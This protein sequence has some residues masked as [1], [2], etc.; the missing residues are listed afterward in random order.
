MK[1]IL[2][3]VLKVKKHRYRTYLK[4]VRYKSLLERQ[5]QVYLQILV[6]FH[7]PGSALPIR[8]PDPEYPN[9]YGSG[10]ITL[11]LPPVLFLQNLNADEP[12]CR[13]IPKC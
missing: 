8:Y 10:S 12:S 5:E 2:Q 4:M 1:N 9:E 3:V 6:N 7:A 13:K 11:T